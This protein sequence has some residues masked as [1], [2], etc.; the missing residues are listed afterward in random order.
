[1]DETDD[2]D[3]LTRRNYL[4]GGGLLLGTSI[5][6]GCSSHGGERP[7]TATSG[8]EEAG[9]STPSDGGSYVASLS[10]VGEVEFDSVPENV[11]TMYN[12]YADMLVALNHGDAVNSMFVPD[13]AGP[14][15]DHYYERLSG[16]SFD[17]N[18][19]PNPYDNFSK[20][21]FYSLGSDVH[22]LDP[23]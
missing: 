8:G 20:E 16:V 18:G 12:Q 22:F 4:A 1:M 9:T 3:S 11:F 23:A 17:W 14:S 10:P 19:L 7:S 5:V 13:M 21:L 15:M 6:A 2:I